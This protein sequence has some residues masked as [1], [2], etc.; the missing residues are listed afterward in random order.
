MLRSLAT[1]VVGP[2][3]FLVN[4]SLKHMKAYHFYSKGME[5]PLTWSWTALR[6][7]PLVSLGE[8][9]CH[10]K[11]VEPYSPWS[12]S[13]EIAIK[14]LRLDTSRDLGQSQSPKVLWDDCLERRAYIKSLTT[15]DHCSLQGEGPETLINGETPDIDAF[16]EFG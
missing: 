8:S 5:S 9:G 3:H 14:T 16:G 4:L 6:N 11:Q 12:N 13:A 1:H 10:I 15:N 2:E 7:K